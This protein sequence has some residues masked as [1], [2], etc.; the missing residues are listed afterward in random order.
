MNVHV[1][2][3]KMCHHVLADVDLRSIYKSRGFP[4][5]GSPSRSYLE[6]AFLSEIG[7]DSV[8]SSLTPNEI[9]FLHLLK[10]NDKVVDISFFWNLYGVGGEVGRGYGTVTTIYRDVLK[11]VKI[12]FVRKG[13]LIMTES[14][15]GYQMSKMEKW[16]FLF[17]EAL[18]AKLPAPFSSSKRLS[19]PGVVDNRRLRK[20]IMD[21]RDRNKRPTTFRSNYSMDIMDGIL[22][23]G[24]KTFSTRLLLKRL[25][26]G[27]TD[28][29]GIKQKKEDVSLVIATLYGF[30]QLQ[31]NEWIP[32]SA[33]TPLL[34]Y[35]C[36][37]VKK[38]NPEIV[39]Q[40]GWEWGLL[41]KQSV[42]D[43][44]WYQSV[45]S[46]LDEGEIPESDYLSDQGNGW[47]LV[48]QEK[49]PL[50]S[51][52]LLATISTMT[53]DGTNLLLKPHFIRMGRVF[54]TIQSHPLILWLKANSPAFSKEMDVMVKRY[55]KHVIHENLLIAKIQDLSLKV[56]IERQFL[57]SGKVISLS[58]EFIAFSKGILPDIEQIIKKSGHVI[59]IAS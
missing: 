14:T 35:F 54:L 26:A 49:I 42:G 56:K 27:W 33:L 39:C 31:S 9:A 25:Q 53:V 10:F 36:P 20:R 43:K 18:A 5:K 21:I 2:L 1:M 3:E 15:S 59:K 55:G 41:A 44:T 34:K 30:L 48:N 17:P 38:L 58:K 32:S 16:R 51:L 45:K 12:S 7:L 52:E 22:Y 28:L 40:I 23:L 11:N 46:P 50:A 24:E 13:V 19:G 47:V 57:D 8:Y 29:L 4:T 6:T 37:S